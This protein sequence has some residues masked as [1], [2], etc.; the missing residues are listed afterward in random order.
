MKREITEACLLENGFTEKEITIF[1]NILSQVENNR[2]C[3]E[4]LLVDLRKRFFGGCILLFVIVI[5]MAPS[6]IREDFNGVI[7]NIALFTGTALLAY[8]I[9]PLKLGWKACRF[10]KKN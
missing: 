5:F 3:Y 6:T 2:Q 8:Y 7:I 1:N 9:I 10:L 4:N